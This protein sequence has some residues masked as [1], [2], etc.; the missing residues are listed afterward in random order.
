MTSTETTL[1]GKESAKLNKRKRFY[2]KFERRIQSLESEEG[3]VNKYIPI[4]FKKVA[5]LPEYDDLALLLNDFSE[6]IEDLS[7]ESKI[8]AISIPDLD[9]GYFLKN[10]SKEGLIK[11]FKEETFENDDGSARKGSSGSIDD[12]NY[13]SAFNFYI[14]VIKMKEFLTKVGKEAENPT[15]YDIKVKMKKMPKKKYVKTFK[16]PRRRRR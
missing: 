14:Q 9:E 11:I 1:T 4:M 13:Q 16:Y 7:D 15:E 3:D 12:Y 2:S 8:E 5:T 6:K 10:M